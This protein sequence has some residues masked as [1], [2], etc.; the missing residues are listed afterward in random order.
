MGLSNTEAK[1]L[2]SK[3]KEFSNQRDAEEKKQEEAQ[4]DVEELKQLKQELTKL[5]NKFNK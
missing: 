4:R 2:I 1:T 3:V 5:I